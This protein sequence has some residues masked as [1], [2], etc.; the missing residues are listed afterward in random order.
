[1]VK[2]PKERE[3]ARFLTPR[4]WTEG[5]AKDVVKD[6]PIL[7]PRA[8]AKRKGQEQGQVQGPMASGPV[9]GDS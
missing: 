6:V 1:M 8:K 3:S 5:L 4:M 7:K 9:A 2:T